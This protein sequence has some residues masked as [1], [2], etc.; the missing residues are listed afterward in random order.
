MRLPKILFHTGFVLILLIML[1]GI[2][3]L[4]HFDVFRMKNDSDAVSGASVKLPDQPSGEFIVLLNRSLHEDTAADWKKF[5]TGEELAVIFDDINCIA[6][7]GDITGIQLA[8]RFQAQLPENQ[9]KLRTE[10]ATLLA[11]KAENHYI[12]AAVFSKEMAEAIQ[13][14]ETKMKNM[15]VIKVSGGEN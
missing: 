13:L 14:S 9:M 12:D 10:N 2:P 3:V 5:F 15:I 7:E 4:T 8:E 6:A 11:S 1:I